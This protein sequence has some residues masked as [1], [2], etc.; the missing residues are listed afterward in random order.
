MGAA[1]IRSSRRERPLTP[2]VA[3]RLFKVVATIATNTTT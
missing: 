2:A 1:A 3:R